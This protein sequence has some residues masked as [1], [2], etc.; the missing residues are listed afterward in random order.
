MPQLITFQTRSDMC[1]SLDP[2]LIDIYKSKPSGLRYPLIT[3][4]VFKDNSDT[5][6][7]LAV[8]RVN[9]TYGQIVDV[10][11]KVRD[12]IIETPEGFKATALDIFQEKSPTKRSAAS[13]MAGTVRIYSPTL[14]CYF[15]GK[16]WKKLDM[17]FE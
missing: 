5:L 14:S 12:L 2:G 6:V 1:I 8:G 4:M 17:A 10:L 9:I 13:K 7:N 15:T 3:K 11:V 16:N